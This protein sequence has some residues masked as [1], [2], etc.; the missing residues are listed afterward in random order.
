MVLEVV[1]IGNHGVHLPITTQLDYIPRQYLST[2][3]SRD[4]NTINLLG[5]SVANP[6]KG[7][8]PNSSSLNGST[9]ALQQLLIPFPQY[10]APGPPTSTSNGVVM[11]GNTP[12][13]SYFQSL[14]VRLQKRLTN[15]LTLINNFVYSKLIDRLA[16][17]NDSDPE[18]EKRVS[19]DSRPLREIV[20]A[21][22]DLPIGRNQRIDLR[23]RLG[24]TLV[25][26]W[27]L[28]A[29][30]TLQS[31]PVLGTWGNVIYLGGPL[32]LQQH[33]PNGV[34]FDTTRFNTA[35]SQQLSDNIR[36]FDTQFGN[37]RRDPT[38]NVDMSMSK[39][40]PIKEKKY[41][42]IRIE[43]FNTAN[44]VTF[45]EPNISPTSSAF[46]MISTQVNSPRAVQLGVRLVW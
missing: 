23:S 36:T 24:N 30:L 40:F 13:S 6:F 41:L 16:Y 25:G 33:Q 19:S 1:Y 44:R 34:A 22:Y 27:K 32:N 12:G 9:V 39:N 28:N 5:G 26:E 42:Q 45:G 29:M 20:A 21:T 10:P 46:G 2:S 35:S 14:N 11:Q 37:L 38:K 43:T 31:G 8:L 3:P 18:P 4:Q 15:G 7:L 17:L